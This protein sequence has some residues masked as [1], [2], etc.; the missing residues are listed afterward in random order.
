MGG[1]VLDYETKQLLR[2]GRAEGM[3]E[4]NSLYAWLRDNGR[5]DDIL[6]AIGDEDFLNTLLSEFKD[7]K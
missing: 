6:R 1:Q 2:E 3:T 5:T 4:V 7:K